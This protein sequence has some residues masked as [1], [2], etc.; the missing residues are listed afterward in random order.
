[1]EACVRRLANAHPGLP[2]TGPGVRQASAI[3]DTKDIRDQVR[4]GLDCVDA[5][6][7]FLDGVPGERMSKDAA[8]WVQRKLREPSFGQTLLT[9]RKAGDG[10]PAPPSLPSLIETRGTLT[11]WRERLVEIERELP[12]RGRPAHGHCTGL[13]AISR[14]F[15]RPREAPPP[16]LDC[17]TYT[18]PLVHSN[19]F[20][21]ACMKPSRNTSDPY[22][23]EA[24]P[25]PQRPF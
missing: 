7:R 8:S 22:L 5:L 15:S 4:H 17:R 10:A 9:E 12:D 20:S 2:A 6:M 13:S 19:A 21:K 14:P 23:Q 1:M 18:D 16:A 11:Q 25:S 24:R 3:A